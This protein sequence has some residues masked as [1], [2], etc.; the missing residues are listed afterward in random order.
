[1]KVANLSLYYVVHT[2][3]TRLILNTQDTRHKTVSA[4]FYTRFLGSSSVYEYT[5][6]NICDTKMYS[7][8]NHRCVYSHNY[9]TEYNC[10]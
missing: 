7:T 9:I 2:I 6:V 8:H 3:C 5:Y 4:G 1:M 10:S